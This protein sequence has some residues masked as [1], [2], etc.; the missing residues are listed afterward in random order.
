MAKPYQQQ[1]DELEERIEKL[2]T[3]NLLRFTNEQLWTIYYALDDQVSTPHNKE[4][5][6]MIQSVA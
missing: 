5:M 4:I 3:K 6:R 2:E 1:I